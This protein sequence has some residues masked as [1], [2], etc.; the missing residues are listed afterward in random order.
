MHLEED[1]L[2]L[3]PTILGRAID[4]VDN[5]R[6]W[7]RDLGAEL[8]DTRNR[9]LLWAGGGGVLLLIV[10]LAMLISSGTRRAHA[11][12]PPDAVAPPAELLAAADR[13]DA[14]VRGRPR[15]S[16]SV[17][18]LFSGKPTAQAKATKRS[19]RRK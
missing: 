2:D 3:P 9:K 12:A 1:D 16:P 14:G 13:H 7:L 6:D 18:A 8:R 10:A 4:A 17:Q 11:A 19:R 15:V 5:A